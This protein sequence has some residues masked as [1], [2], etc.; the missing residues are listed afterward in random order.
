VDVKQA[1]KPCP[2]CGG[3]DL[4][5]F[6]YPFKRKPGLKGCYIK[7]KKCGATT[8][9]YETIEDAG[10]AWNERQPKA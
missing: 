4:C 9:N 3:L 2:F 5:Q 1:L 7:C 10:N 6:I 8:G